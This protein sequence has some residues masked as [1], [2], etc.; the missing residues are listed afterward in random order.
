MAEYICEINT[1]LAHLRNL[2]RARCQ[3]DGYRVLAQARA[4][5]EGIT[6]PF[7]KQ[8]LIGAIDNARLAYQKMPKKKS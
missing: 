8:L 4:A 5:S 6:E 2:G 3:N 7:A 1:A